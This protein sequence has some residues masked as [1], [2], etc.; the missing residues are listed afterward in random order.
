[1]KIVFRSSRVGRN[2]NEHN[3]VTQ[4][5]HRPRMLYNADSKLN[6]QNNYHQYGLR[7]HRSERIQIRVCFGKHIEEKNCFEQCFCP[8]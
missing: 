6:T 1:M 7:I 8:S 3:D 4:Q 5:Q 2:E